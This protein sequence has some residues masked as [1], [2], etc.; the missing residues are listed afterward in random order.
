[1]ETKMVT[2]ANSKSGFNVTFAVPSFRYFQTMRITATPRMTPTIP[3]KI[4]A[5][6]IMLPSADVS[7][8]SLLQRSGPH[9]L[10]AFG[11]VLKGERPADLPMARPTKF[12][13]I[14]LLG[15]EVPPS[16]L[17]TTAR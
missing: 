9:I 4:I 14:R 5:T 17:A 11:R 15:I 8:R 12:E 16:L 6:A 7:M 3:D 10:V 13:F 2:N 1:M